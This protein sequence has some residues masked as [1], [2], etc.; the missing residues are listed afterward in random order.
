LAA[1]DQPK[2]AL[3]HQDL[4]LPNAPADQRTYLKILAAAAHDSKSLAVIFP[5]KSRTQ[6]SSILEE[7]Q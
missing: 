1:P 5:P 4:P 3:V 7:A 6:V 2:I